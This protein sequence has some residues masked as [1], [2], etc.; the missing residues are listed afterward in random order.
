MR[1][2][3]IGACTTRFKIEQLEAVLQQKK[4]KLAKLEHIRKVLTEREQVGVMNVSFFHLLTCS[5]HRAEQ[6]LLLSL[7]CCMAT[8]STAEQA[9]QCTAQ[10][11]I[12]QKL[13]A[14]EHAAETPHVRFAG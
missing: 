10:P 1:Q 14:T 6:S 2:L 7:C 5:L 3:N 9:R 11:S 4:K 8:R 13:Q 12:L